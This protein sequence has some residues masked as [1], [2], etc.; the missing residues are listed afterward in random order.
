MTSTHSPGGDQPADSDKSVRVGLTAAFFRALAHEVSNDADL[1]PAGLSRAIRGVLPV[2]GAGLSTMASV[3]RMPL[4]SSSE[5][6]AQAEV[7][8]TS[9]GEG[10]CLA[11]A[12]AQAPMIA[13]LADLTARWPTYAEE[14]TAKTP[15][16]AVAAIPLYAPG[17]GVFA[18]LDLYSINPQLSS[19][20]DLAEVDE[21][22]AAPAAALL[23]TC[24][25]QVR[26]VEIQAATPE[27][28][29]GATG[30]R[31][32]VWVAVGMVM[33]IRPGR[34]GDALSLLRAHAYTQG[35]SLDDLAPT[36]S[37]AGYP[38]PT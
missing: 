3:L 16:R 36:S 11:A 20:L 33:A 25:E 8:Q 37:T 38:R 27:W 9:L 10:P 26:D 17:R 1:T 2:D 15:F 4:G 31:H 30:R 22:V 21:R 18:A 24:L 28:Y 32:D 34:T 14:L 23:T 6:A 7:L 12:E 13:D 5:A 35:R 19:R 29:Q